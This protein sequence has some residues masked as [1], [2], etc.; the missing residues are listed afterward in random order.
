MK[1]SVRLK[2]SKDIIK[3]TTRRTKLTRETT[4]VHLLQVLGFQDDY[5]QLAG[6]GHVAEGE[7]NVS[8]LSV[9]RNEC[10][11][12]HEV[13]EYTIVNEGSFGLSHKPSERAVIKLRSK[14]VGRKSTA[15]LES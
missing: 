8:Q 4:D 12:P 15:I 14:I 2:Q 1:T 11:D 9:L 10:N 13:F 7:A 3:S 5:G 6:S